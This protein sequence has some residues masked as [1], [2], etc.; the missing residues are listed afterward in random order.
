MEYTLLQPSQR[1]PAALLSF[2]AAQCTSTSAFVSL[3]STLTDMTTEVVADV[4]G[5]Y[6]AWG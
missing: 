6:Q 3:S 1:E 5:P 4:V 2:G